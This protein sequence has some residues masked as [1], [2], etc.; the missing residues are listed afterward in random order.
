MDRAENLRT[1]ESIQKRGRW[2]SAKSVHRYREK[3]TC[4]P[5]LVSARSIGPGTL[6]ALR[7]TSCPQYCFMVTPLRH[8]LDCSVFCDRSLQC[9]HRFAT[10]FLEQRCTVCKNS[11]LFLMTTQ[12]FSTRL[13][14]ILRILASGRTL[15][16]MLSPPVSSLSVLPEI[17]DRCEARHDLGD[18][19][20]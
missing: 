3:R 2:K 20:P 19:Q 18:G 7:A 5:K 4:Q 1:L 6:R 16:V 13:Q 9:E 11:I 8:R 15:A 10:V 14:D 17:T 12:F